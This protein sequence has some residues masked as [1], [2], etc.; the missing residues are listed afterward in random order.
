MLDAQRLELHVAPSERDRIEQLGHA[1]HRSN[2]PTP[3]CLAPQS[4]PGRARRE[5]GVPGTET[6]KAMAG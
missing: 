5:P 1:G 6:V 3:R 4:D 2:E